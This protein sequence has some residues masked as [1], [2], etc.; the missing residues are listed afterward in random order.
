MIGSRKKKKNQVYNDKTEREK[1]A[2]ISTS[3]GSTETEGDC[4]KGELGHP[5]DITQGLLTPAA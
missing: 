4:S 5:N 1:A 2:L 3:P